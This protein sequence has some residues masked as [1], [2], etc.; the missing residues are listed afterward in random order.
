M[1]YIRSDQILETRSLQ[2]THKWQGGRR[3][4][5]G[6]EVGCWR[7]RW[8]LVTLLG[9][10]PTPACLGW[11][12]TFCLPGSLLPDTT[13]RQP[14]FNWLTEADLSDHSRRKQASSWD[15]AAAVRQDQKS[16]QLLQM[17]TMSLEKRK[18]ERRVVSEPRALLLWSEGSYCA[19]W[20]V[21]GTP[22]AQRKWPIHVA[23]R[24]KEK[25]VRS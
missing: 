14:R 25:N 4:L 24:R 16:K 2:G 19:L 6:E 15:S 10:P 8:L 21:P 13:A 3:H 22:R 20:L 5:L 12:G 23:E 1:G 18:R 7:A 11:S 9:V 17:K